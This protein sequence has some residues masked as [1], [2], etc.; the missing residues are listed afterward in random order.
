MHRDHVTRAAACY[1]GFY[2][3][4]THPHSP[5]SSHTVIQLDMQKYVL[6]RHMEY[7][8]VRQLRHLFLDRG[9][10][11]SHLPPLVLQLHAAAYMLCDVLLGAHPDWMLIVACNLMQSDAIRWYA[12][13]MS[14]S[15]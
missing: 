11:K 2:R 6:D 13:F 12:R 9:K 14:F 3:P 7:V 1:P 8:P 10:R 5:T 15:A 4:S